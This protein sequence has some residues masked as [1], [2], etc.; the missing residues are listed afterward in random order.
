MNEHIADTIISQLGGRKIFGMIGVKSAVRLQN[1][2]QLRV[3]AKSQNKSN[4]VIIKLNGRDLYDVQF[5]YA[6]GVGYT[7]RGEYNNV[8]CDTLIE[9]FERETALYLHF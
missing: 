2:L 8:Y 1:G 3:S 6:R 4:V 5:G 9:L 7:I